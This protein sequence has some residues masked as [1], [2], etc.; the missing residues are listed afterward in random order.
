LD[1]RAA[2]GPAKM[3]RRP[4]SLNGNQIALS[5]KR[6]HMQSKLQMCHVISGELRRHSVSTLFMV[7][8]LV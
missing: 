5:S 3:K 7:W 1:W 4:A 2:G 8:Y 6:Y